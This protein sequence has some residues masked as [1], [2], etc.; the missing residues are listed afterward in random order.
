MSQKFIIPPRTTD[1]NEIRKFFVNIC[2]YINRMM[3]VDNSLA[4]AYL[5]SNQA[6]NHNEATTVTGYTESSDT[7][8]NFNAT[9]GLYTA[10]VAGYYR[11]DAT[12]LFYDAQSKLNLG[13]TYV[14][15]NTDLYS[16]GNYW[17]GVDQ[18]YVGSSVG[19]FI[20]LAVG[21]TLKMAGYMQTSDSSAA[22]MLAGAYT[23]FSVH[24]IARA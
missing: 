19:D 13:A 6:I 11:F 14:Y 21:D 20:S 22:V 5:T 1:G 12:I 17:M 15:K 9:T 4:R 7:G 10:A 3:E 16:S 24:L 2:Q 18:G 23:H 8:S